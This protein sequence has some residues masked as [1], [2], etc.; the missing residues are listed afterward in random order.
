MKHDEDAQTL[1]FG[2]QSFIML[3]A[4]TTDF[5]SSISEGPIETGDGIG[6]LVSPVML[7]FAQSHV[8][9]SSSQTNGSLEAFTCGSELF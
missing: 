6:P 2:T 9:E 4:L 7:S 8:S 5:G 1:V 3:N